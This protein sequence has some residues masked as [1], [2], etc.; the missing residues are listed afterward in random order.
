MVS[1]AQSVFDYGQSEEVY[2]LSAKERDSLGIYQ[3]L[4]LSESK[5]S[6][7][8]NETWDL[9]VFDFAPAEYGFKIDWYIHLDTMGI[10]TFDQ[11]ESNGNFLNWEEGRITASGAYG[12][13]TL[14]ETFFY[15]KGECLEGVTTYIRN[16]E[17]FSGS[18]TYYQ[19]G[20]PMKTVYFD[21]DSLSYFDVEHK[22]NRV[23]DSLAQFPCD[24]IIRFYDKENRFFNS[25]NNKTNTKL[26]H[27]FYQEKSTSNLG[28]NPYYQVLIEDMEMRDFIQ[29]KLG[30]TPEVL[31]FEVYRYA[32]LVFK[33]DQIHNKY[34][35]D[36]F[37]SLEE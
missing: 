31:I 32:A 8:M 35:Y 12:Y 36:S 25:I 19:K 3:I 37:L 1:F 24:S 27:Y 21:G 9:L 20:L 11:V 10:D 7:G 18:K 6:G 30:Y 33:I 14:G 29:N 23:L 34:Y 17:M 28:G 13:G 2:F 15:S 26:S 22:L 4:E 16:T 5:S